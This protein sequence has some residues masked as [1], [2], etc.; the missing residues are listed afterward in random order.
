MGVVEALASRSLKPTDF[1]TFADEEVF[2]ESG[3]FLVV[4]CREDSGFVPI[5][6]AIFAYAGVLRNPRNIFLRFR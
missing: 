2:L 3:F 4:E 6:R 5:Y 1:Q